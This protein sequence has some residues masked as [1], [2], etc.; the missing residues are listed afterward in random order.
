MSNIFENIGSSSFE[1]VLRTMERELWTYGINVISC[2]ISTYKGTIMFK[3]ESKLYGTQCI[4]EVSMNMLNNF[5]YESTQKYANQI[6]Q[7]VVQY[8]RYPLKR[9]VV[10][11]A[12]GNSCFALDDLNYFPMRYYDTCTIN[13]I[14]NIPV[15]K[16]RKKDIDR[17]FTGEET[18]AKRKEEAKKYKLKTKK[19]KEPV[20]LATKE[21]WI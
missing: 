19:R 13:N 2:D 8:L 5:D 15:K 10:H 21:M 9:D 14:D 3:F 17:R 4:E 7:T 11:T 16:K 20:C 18:L 6:V 12:Y 1:Y